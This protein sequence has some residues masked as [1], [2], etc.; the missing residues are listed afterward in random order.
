MAVEK[1]QEANQRPVGV[2]EPPSPNQ[3]KEREEVPHPKGFPLPHFILKTTL[4][5]R[6]Y[7]DHFIE[8]KTET[9][10]RENPA[11]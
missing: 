10:R 8:E 9:Q 5:G 11:Y 6:F 2:A 1:S 7:E 3:V 4:E